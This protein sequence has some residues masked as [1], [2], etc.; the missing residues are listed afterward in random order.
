MVSLK[1]WIELDIEIGGIVLNWIVTMVV[2]SLAALS[3]RLLPGIEE[4]PEI[5]WMKM[6]DDMKLIELWIDHVQGGDEMRASHKDLL[7]VQ[8][9]M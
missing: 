6:E 1:T 4:W 9:S 7:S 2:A 5:H 3:A 8:K